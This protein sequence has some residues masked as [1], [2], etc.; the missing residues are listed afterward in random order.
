MKFLWYIWASKSKKKYQYIL[1]NKQIKAQNR[2]HVKVLLFDKVFIKVLA[3]YF[4]YSNIFLAENI[5]KLLKNPGINKYAIKLE[6]AKQLL[7]SPI[8]C[9]RSVKLET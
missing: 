9:L 3:E 5:T 2:A 1:K 8:Y 6:K 4:N 7:F